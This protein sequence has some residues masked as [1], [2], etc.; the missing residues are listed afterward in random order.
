MNTMN[1]KL[2]KRE[3]RAQQLLCHYITCERLGRLLGMQ[4]PDGKKISVA[5]WKAEKAGQKHGER[6]CNDPHY[7]IVEQNNKTEGIRVSVKAALG[8][9]LPPGFFIN[10]DPRGY[11]LKIDDASPIAGQ[12]REIGMHRDMGGYFILSPEITG[13]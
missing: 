9:T 6:V 3:R 11:A 5:L 2:N 13:D 1:A 8:G 12:L 4:K 10:S 7:L